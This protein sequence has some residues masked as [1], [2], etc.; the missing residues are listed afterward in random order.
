MNSQ[1]AGVLATLLILSGCSVNPPKAPVCDGSDR[2]PVNRTHQPV[3]A[4][5]GPTVD[6]C[7]RG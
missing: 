3:A 5:A 1:I 6:M 7:S 2:R 4:A